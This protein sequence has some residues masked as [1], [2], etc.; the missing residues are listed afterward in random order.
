MDR[1]LAQIG[2][3]VA[4][5]Q[6]TAELNSANCKQSAEETRRMA[7]DSVRSKAEVQGVAPATNGAGGGGGFRS[8]GREWDRGDSGAFKCQYFIYFL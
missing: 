4:E 1:K 2:E 6:A 7:L 3:Q 5:I 8:G